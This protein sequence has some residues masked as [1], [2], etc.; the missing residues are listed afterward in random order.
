MSTL[1]AERTGPADAPTVLLLRPIAGSLAL[2]G[3]FRDELA[4]QWS[5]VACDARGVGRSPPLDGFTSTRQ[6]ARD[7]A[8][9]LES[10]GIGRA[11]VVGLSLGGMVG[12]YLAIDRPDLVD[13]L[14]LASTP[15]R[16]LDLVAAR[17]VRFARC[18]ARS[19]GDREA[20]LAAHVLSPQFR[21]EHPARAR[22]LVEQV[23]SERGALRSLVAHAVAGARHDA[24]A[25]LARIVAPTL[26][27]AGTRDDI[28]GETGTR[29][30]VERIARARLALLDAGHD[31]AFEAPIAFAHAVTSFLR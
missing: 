6:M 31:L 11:H 26:C 19:A 13:R 21:R 27:I 5:V 16:G 3:A 10:L 23:R 14:V 17:H 25:E 12:T 7:A 30:L 2:W 20:C 1:Y 4:Q 9:L 8:E 18:L 29:T 15:A 22:E 28:V 24:R